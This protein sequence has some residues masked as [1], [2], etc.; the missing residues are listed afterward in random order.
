MQE[1][2]AFFFL[3]SKTHLSDL[4]S[5]TFSTAVPVGREVQTVELLFGINNNAY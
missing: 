2:S 1:V 4:W 3:F 5:I